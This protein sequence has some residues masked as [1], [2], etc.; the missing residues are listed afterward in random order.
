MQKFDHNIGFLEKRKFFCR[1]LSKIAENCDLDIGP[2]QYVQKRI[3]LMPH[4]HQKPRKENNG[5]YLFAF[6]IL[7]SYKACLK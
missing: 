5:Q 1:K 4:W 6:S 2:R 3:I 7:L